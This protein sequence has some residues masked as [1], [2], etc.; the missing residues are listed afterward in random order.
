M[1]LRGC[2]FR[3]RHLHISDSDF[4]HGEVTEIDWPLTRP[5]ESLIFSSR[6]LLGCDDAVKCCGRIPSFR[7]NLLPPSSERHNPEESSPPWKPQISRLIFSLTMEVM[8]A[9]RYR[10]P[11]FATWSPIVQTFSPVRWTK[12]TY[13]DFYLTRQWAFGF[14]KWLG[15]FS[16]AE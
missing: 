7:K 1:G 16:L 12:W 2:Y 6:D 10:L 5:D 9:I 11:I 13:Y 4:S 8:A 15:I 3:R 14:H